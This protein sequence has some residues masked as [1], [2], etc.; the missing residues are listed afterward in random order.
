MSGSIL[1]IKL[2]AHRVILLCAVRARRPAARTDVCVR[3]GRRD[4]KE[5]KEAAAAATSASSQQSASASA[6]EGLSAGNVRSSA[7]VELGFNLNATDV[8]P[9]S[10]TPLAM[11]LVTCNAGSSQVE[12]AQM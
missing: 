3:H 5:K 12:P 6:V 11:R 9:P 4:E 2:T 7:Q 8:V 10:S 1:N